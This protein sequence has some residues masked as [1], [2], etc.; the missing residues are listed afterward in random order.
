MG[1]F[2]LLYGIVC[3]A[4]FFATFVYAIGFVGNLIVPKSI[5]IGWPSGAEGSPTEALLVNVALLGVFALQHSVMARPA[6]KRWWTRFVPK[7]VERSTYVLFASAA[8]IL[9]LAQWRPIAAPVV[10]RWRAPRRS[11]SSPS[12]GPA[13]ACCSSAPS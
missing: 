7:A 9:L 5:D 12:I 3:Y 10:W 1:L 8:L 2:A 11:P 6:F 13:G 4:I